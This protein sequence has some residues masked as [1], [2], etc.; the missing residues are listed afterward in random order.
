ML[1][2]RFWSKKI[3]PGQR[4]PLDVPQG[5]S[6]TITNAC[7][8]ESCE[9]PGDS[10]V[11]VILHQP[12][13]SVLLATF[14]PGVAQHAKLAVQA[15]DGEL[16]NAGRYQAHVSGFLLETPRNDDTDDSAH[17]IDLSGFTV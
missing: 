1:D 14:V 16:E 12:S 11:R 3:A 9:I 13:G 4:V 10:P 7:I 5:L 2:A 17:Q 15:T 8:V 6:L